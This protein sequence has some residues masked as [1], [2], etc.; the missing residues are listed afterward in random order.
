MN[1]QNMV[2]S[3]IDMLGSLGGKFD[4]GKTAE[5]VPK[6]EHTDGRFKH[7]RHP[8][9]GKNYFTAG[10][11]YLMRRQPKRDKSIS[12]RQWKKQV[13]AQRRAAKAVEG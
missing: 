4:L 6:K 12:A 3:F 10:R 8:L 9:N 7:G 5:D 1:K 11:G 13:K 2:Q